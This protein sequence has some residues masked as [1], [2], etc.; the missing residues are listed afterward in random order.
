MISKYKVICEFCNALFSVVYGTEDKKLCYEVYSCPLCRNMFSLSNKD[1]LEC[2][3]CNNKCLVEYNP[4]KKKNL[5]YYDDMNKQGLLT[6]ADYDKLSEYWKNIKDAKCPRCGKD[7]LKW[8]VQM[9]KTK[10]NG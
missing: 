7:R 6:Q 10:Q 8:E 4:N 9:D 3:A 2:P 1:S 5:K